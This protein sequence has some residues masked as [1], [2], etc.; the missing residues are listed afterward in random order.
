M[1]AENIIY[2]I[3]EHSNSAR[4]YHRVIVISATALNSKNALSPSPNNQNPNKNSTFLVLSEQ[5][6]L[7]LNCHKNKQY[8][9]KLMKNSF[10]SDEV[11]VGRLVVAVGGRGSKGLS[12]QRVVVIFISRSIRSIRQNIRTSRGVSLYQGLGYATTPC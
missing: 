9:L 3:E 7:N 1:N 2:V 11:S 8:L 10:L 4:G 6:K 5:E 12:R